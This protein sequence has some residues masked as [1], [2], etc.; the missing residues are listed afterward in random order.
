M[1]AGAPG[2]GS[3][4][5]RVEHVE[6]SALLPAVVLV[7][8]TMAARW[9]KPGDKMRSTLQHFAA[10]VVFSTVAVELL[11]DLIRS[12]AV[13][14]VIVGFACGVALLLL[15]RRITHE[16]P[17]SAV[18][19]APARDSK[20][21]TGMLVAVGIDI[22]LDGLLVGLGFT[23]GAKEGWMLTIALSLELLSLGLAIGAS[24]ATFP[25]M[26]VL[27]VGLVLSSSLLVGA[28]G[29]VTFI[30]D[31]SEHALAGVL[32]FGCAALL[33]LVTEELLVEAHESG[34][35]AF[36]TAMFFVGFLAFL[37]VGMIA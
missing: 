25:R 27:T 11:P 21:P 8:A 36:A 13:L 28:A 14:Y 6:L 29:G 7:L 32:A 10:G 1:I 26:R 31:L 20:L 30:A 12:H 23:V 24:L 22:L 33:F 2:W 9:R 15:I 35:T 16:P 37:V 4:F 34:E 19:S 18:A 17:P 3:A 5:Q